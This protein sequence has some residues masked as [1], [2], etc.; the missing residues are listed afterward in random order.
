MS[1]PK[2]QGR[3][4]GFRKEDPLNVNKGIRFTEGEFEGISKAREITKEAESVF[5][6]DAINTKVA[7]VLRK[8]RKSGKDQE[9]QG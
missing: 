8:E 7:K 5:M 2:K 4:V 9:I 3:K 1:E 6:R